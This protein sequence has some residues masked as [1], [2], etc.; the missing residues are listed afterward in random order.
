M[1]AKRYYPDQITWEVRELSAPGATRF[2]VPGATS[3][4]S[5]SPSTPKQKKRKIIF[6]NACAHCLYSTTTGVPQKL[7]QNRQKWR[8]FVAA[9]MQTSF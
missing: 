2:S 9:L 5:A 3:S 8:T 6:K 4:A 7:A 1:M